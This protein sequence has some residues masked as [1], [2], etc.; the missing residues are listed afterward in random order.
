MLDSTVAFNEI[1]YNPAGP[2]ESLEWIELRNQLALDVDLTGWSLQGGIEFEFADNTLIPADGYLV[3]AADL[4]ALAGAGFTDALGPYTGSLSN[5]GETLQLYNNSQ[6][7]MDEFSYEDDG[8]W[9][10]GPDGS[11]ASLA[12]QDEHWSA[13]FADNWRTSAEMGG[14]P[15]RQN[16]LIPDLAPQTTRPV[17]L[18]DDWRYDDTNTDLGT[19]WREPGFDDRSWPEG[20]ALFHA[21]EESFSQPEVGLR[22]LPITA[23]D[24]SGIGADKLYTHALDFGRADGGA[25]VNGVQFTEVRAS[26]LGDVADF[27][28]AVTSGARTDAT[29]SGSANVSGDI[30]ALLQDY[31]SNAINVA[32]GKVTVTLSNLTIGGHYDTRLYT[33]QLAAGT[34][35]ATIEFDS[36]GEAGAE[37]SL[38]I[39]QEDATQDPPGLDAPDRAYAISYDFVAANAELVITITQESFNTPFLLYGLTNEVIGGANVAESID[40]LFGTGLSAEGVPLS[41]GGADPHWFVTATGE[42]LLA[43]SPNPAWVANSGTSQWTGLVPSGSSNVDPGTYSFSTEFDLSNYDA[44]TA[45][46]GMSIAVDDSLTGVRL[47]G[48]DTGIAT[49]GFDSLRGPFTLN[50]GFLPGV[51]TLEFTLVNGGAGPNPSGLFVDFAA[52]AVANRDQTRVTEGPPTHYFRHEFVAGGDPNSAFQLRLNT[53]VDD[54]AVY[55]LNGE[56]I[57][58]QNMPAGPV[59]FDTVA[60]D[61]I[62]IARESGNIVVPSDALRLGE[63]NVLAVEVHQ[64]DGNTD[65]RFGAELIL[66]ETPAPPAAPP[67]LVINELAAAA[68]DT[69]FVEL[70]NSDDQAVD[71]SNFTLR[72]LGSL[73]ADYELPDLELPPG[74]FLTATAAQLGGTLESGDRLFLVA[75][76]IGAVI[77]ARQVGDRL[78]GRSGRHD[79]AWLYP[80]GPSMNAENLFTIHDEVVINEIMYHPPPQYATPPATLFAESDEEWIEIYNRS[81]GVVDLTDW[82]VD[83]G[84]QFDFA[85]GTILAAGEYAVIARDSD[86]LAEKYPDIRILG[87][88]TGRLSDFSEQILIEDSQGNP[89]D[90]VTY[91]EGGRWPAVADGGGSSLELRDPH[92]D[93]SKAEAWATS[94]ESDDSQWQTIT[95]RGLAAESP[96]TN[97]PAVWNE[98]VFGLLDA[99]ELLVDDISVIEDPDGAAIER[100]QNGSFEN[101]L[102]AWRLMGNHGQHGLSQVIEEP[103]GAGNHVLHLV[104]TGATEHMS[105]HVETTFAENADI[106]RGQEYEISLRVRWL[107]GS[108]QLHTRLYFNR[109]ART[110][111]VQVPDLLG[112]P[113]KPNSTYMPNV[114]PTFDQLRHAPA[115][116]QPGQPVTVSVQA[117]DPDNVAQLKLWYSVDG[118]AFQS[119][120]MTA[121]GDLT[122][123]GTIPGQA[124]KSI[125]QFYVEGQDTLGATAMFPDTGPESRALFKVNDNAAI[126]GPQHNFRMIMTAD[127]TEFQLTEANYLSNHR[128]G[129]TVVFN[130][131]QVYY[132]VGVRLKGSGFS[133][134]SAATGYNLRFQPE[135]LLFGVHDVVAIDRQGGPWGIGA[136]H[137]EL[138]LKQIGNRAGGIPMMYDDAI[139]LIAPNPGF[140]G[141]AQLLAARYDN[142]FLDSQYENGSDGTRLKFELVYYSTLTQTGNPE[143]IKRP[144][145]FFPAGVFPVLGVDLRNMGDDANAYRWNYLIRNNRAEDDFSRIIDMAKA[146]SLSGS[147][148]DGPL[149][150]A[151]QD[152]IDVDQWMRLFAFESLVGINDTYNQGLPHN[153]QFYVRPSDKRVLALPWDMDFAFHQSTT[154]P[155]YGTGSNLRK[156]INIPANQRLFQG[157]LQDILTTAYNVDYLT[158]WVE[159]IATRS[160][161]NN[162]AEILNYVTAR[163]NYVLGQLPPQIDFEITTNDGADFTVDQQTA[164]ITGRGW[165]NV[166]EIRL[167]GSGTSQNVKWLDRDTWQ[168][169]VPLE[170]G[171][172][173]I[174]LEAFD[175]QGEWIARDSVQIT[176]TAANPVIDAL[177]I[178]EINYNPSGPTAAELAVR[179]ALD[180]DD[181]EFIEIQNIGDASINLLNARISG[182]VEFV[183]PPGVLAAGE[184]AV[185]VQ[186]LAAFQ[187]RY[188][189]DPRVIG[190][191]QAGRL[192]N[193]GESIS[194]HDALGQTIVEIEYDD[195]GLW[196][197]S[198]DGVGATLV[199]VSPQTTAR[200]DYGKHYAWRHSTEFGG[201]PA[202]LN[203]SPIG[204]VINEILAHTEPPVSD[205]IELFNSTDAAIDISGWFLSDAA[206]A[207]WKFQIPAGTVL[208]PKQ[209][210]LFDE[211]D[212]NPTQATPAPNHFALSSRGDDVWLTV[213]NGQEGEATFVDE[214]H[215]GATLLGEA[216]GRLPNGV[217]PLAPL[218]R[219]TL[220]CGNGAP[221]VGP[222]IVSELNYNPGEPS[223]AA[224]AIDP[225]LVED[226]LEFVE[227]HNPTGAPVVLTDWR[228]AGGVEFRVEA[229]VAIAPGETIVVLSFD[230]QAAGNASRGAA[231]RAH[232][233]LDGSI[234]LLGGFADQLSDRGEVVRWERVDLTPRDDPAVAYVGEDV[235]L[236]DDRLEWPPSAD[237]GGDSLQRLAPVFFGSFATSWQAAA[238]TPGTVDFGN[239]RRGD[240]NGDNLL[241][242]HDMDALWS[243]VRRGS[244]V[245]YFDLNGDGTLNQLDV[246]DLVED[247]IGSRMGDVNLDGVVDGLDFNIWNDNRFSACNKSW[248]DGDLS[249]DGKV[250]GSD[251]N[252]WLDNRF[253]GQPPAADA[254]LREPRAPA[255]FKARPVAKRDL[256]A[257]DHAWR[258]FNF[259]P[260]SASF[261]EVEPSFPVDRPR[262]NLRDTRSSTA[263]NVGGIDDPA[264]TEI[265]SRSLDSELVDRVMLSLN[266]PLSA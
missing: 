164:L 37:A 87:S 160:V 49:S 47:N 45:I 142:V 100:I 170:F 30:A 119:A 76:D 83:G 82:K 123:L 122:Y 34:R 104:A 46:V 71:L 113:G 133:R 244:D 158:P 22:T 124:A 58:R 63:N 226:D 231:F 233:G 135:Q 89:V 80:I 4:A 237:G 107:S 130:E 254:S 33:R 219:L 41:P 253:T 228:I 264:T 151:T 232:Y 61:N 14:T 208:D 68:S 70:T 85:A 153:L 20:Q 229:G 112:T 129:A 121:G 251:F 90:E 25:N 32:G 115:I 8:A 176:S 214:V 106:L 86:A 105:N 205:A 132:D 235:V 149:D 35:N 183:F 65:V 198:A 171:A 73:E 148:V 128:L 96:G 51:N 215:F 97:N 240:F 258:R 40:T 118:D 150:L 141:T 139:Y 55:Y 59:T 62:P 134:G 5:G 236:Y 92:A 193:G 21:G 69:F 188:G 144:P 12:K 159:H 81:A 255:E 98:F 161:Q 50:T 265:E 162:T 10:V 111:I 157:H 56:E 202:A 179:P 75:N 110:T 95:Y 196:P 108:P 125:V 36:D 24:D 190:E 216:A 43:M 194:L 145:G 173:D 181:F 38:S 222:L 74:G 16:F 201:A 210:V 172:N 2:D 60:T 212:F 177:R 18:F 77:D 209:Y 120:T 57:Y 243:A 249:G 78:R 175:F 93:N 39:N 186:D 48:V 114:G 3:I 247:L 261:A 52:T 245:G 26:G 168:L 6:R 116:P 13:A 195:G 53:I 11:G 72:T 67:K 238:P 117:T 27:S 7:L 248:S 185:V 246:T 64:A 54:G 155:I 31:V 223:L 29:G 221:R 91:F 262:H 131:S 103:G 199:A 137:R 146:F 154:M 94:V 127:D 84:I 213:P 136:S 256:L 224:L 28:Y 166:R 169:V 140:N 1:M 197:E 227:I 23:D 206:D 109:L 260:T 259:V 165:I 239:N 126:S 143:A 189:T 182:G 79:G 242:A 9:P 174:V 163:R 192:D 167:A 184:Y 180:N 204:I 156:V 250:D 101:G 19:A 152:V 266:D 252:V 15:G 102:N 207:L 66:T 178:T 200:T 187:L 263:R 147:S 225:N 217:G 88:F 138:T 17:S 230:P 218:D 257:I 234:R 220:G 211:T 191:F 241:D 42:P 203:S 99:G 44:S